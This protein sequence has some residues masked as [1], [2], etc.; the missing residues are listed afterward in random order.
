VILTATSGAGSHQATGDITVASGVAPCSSPIAGFTATPTSGTSPL[1]VQF[2]DT[3]VEDGCPI[4]TWSWDFGDGSPISTEPDPLHEFTYGG[5]DPST[6]YT[7][8][9]TVTSDAGSSQITQA[10]TVE[11]GA[12]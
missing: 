7:V 8:T 6:S 1:E 4:V 12:P 2:S 5:P 10:V 3:S 9:L 11:A